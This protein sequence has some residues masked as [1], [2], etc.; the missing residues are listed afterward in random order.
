MINK[1][2]VWDEHGE[3]MIYGVGL[4][5]DGIAYAVPKNA[6]APDQYDY[7]PECPVMQY[8]G[9]KD[10]DGNEICGGDAV[11]LYLKDYG[12]MEKPERFIVNCDKEFFPDVC[13]LQQIEAH[14]NKSDTNDYIKIVGNIYENPELLGGAK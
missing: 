8:T 1:L 2:R 13:Y 12:D 5:P 4:D 11:E 7:F 14:I 10:M 3:Q 9:V 6:E